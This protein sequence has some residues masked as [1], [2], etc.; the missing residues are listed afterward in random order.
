MKKLEFILFG[1][2]FVVSCCAFGAMV[3]VTNGEFDQG[4]QAFWVPGWSPTTTVNKIFYNPEGS[5]DFWDETFRVPES[6]VRYGWADGCKLWQNSTVATLHTI[7]ADT[8]YTM[9]V[10]A[11]V[12]LDSATD[13]IGLELSNATNWDV[14]AQEFHYN[15]GGIGVWN[16]YS[17][18][19]DTSLP[20][21]SGFV[22]DLLAPALINKG[23]NNYQLVDYVRIDAVPEPATIAL[24]GL[25][26]TAVFGSRK[27]K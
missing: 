14:I 4:E 1:V 27:R 7:E 16:E 2:L 12:S 8:V 24:M 6:H 5:M 17:I 22:G 9:T 26:F 19:F 21:Y 13:G 3:P 25:G 20:E 10:R 23:G 15:T 11:M 18:S